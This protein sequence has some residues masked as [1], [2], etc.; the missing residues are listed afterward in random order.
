MEKNVK[1]FVC[2]IFFYGEHILLCRELKASGLPKCGFHLPGGELPRGK[3]PYKFLL[4][5]INIKY[6]G[7]IEILK[8]LSPVTVVR[9]NETIVLYPFYCKD[10]N[11]FEYPKHIEHKYFRFNEVQDIYVDPCDKFVI[12]KAIHYQ[13]LVRGLKKTVG[14]G[15]SKQ[16]YNYMMA[17]L[18]YYSKRLPKSEIIDFKGLLKCDVTKKEAE[19]AFKWLLN[20]YGLDYGEFLDQLICLKKVERR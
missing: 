6:K 1:K 8:E 4:D 2:G 3:Q 5:C 7:H 13:K 9:G 10:L 16:E 20:A 14:H 11:K 15:L 17:A 12:Y 18:R 19:A